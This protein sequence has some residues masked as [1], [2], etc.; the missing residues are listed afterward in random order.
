[1]ERRR[2]FVLAPLIIAGLV[3]LVQY[4][5]SERFVNPETGRA[6]R[7]ALS[8][9]QETQLGLQSYRQVL[10]QE[11][12]LTGGPEV[13]L[14]TRVA[15]RLAAVTGDAA[16]QMDWQVSVVR[17]PQVNAFCL[18]GGKI[19]V[20]TGILP[21]ARTEAGLATV[22]GHEM[23]HATS[24]HGAQRLFQSQMANTL[25]Q[26]AQMSVA[27]GDLPVDQQRTILGAIGAGAKF[28]VILPFSREH[29]SEA[30]AVG[31][32]YMARAG[33]DPRESVGFWQR[34]AE[35]SQGGQPPEFASTHPAHDTRIENLKA[36]MPRAIQEY[37]QAAAGK[38]P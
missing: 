35:A 27:L 36:L 29:E 23:A 33:Y 1:M 22:M 7:V 11:D 2:K 12:V 26:G 18:P 20:Y 14:V 9:E 32:L 8:P 37:E 31:L 6:A 30:D 17:S 10:A 16:R 13:D 28:G 34:M 4:F 3:V 15:Q 19:V 24:R 38:K 5:G 25:M 21:V